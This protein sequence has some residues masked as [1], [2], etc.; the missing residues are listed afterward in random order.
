M[1]APKIKYSILD[2]KINRLGFPIKTRQLR[3][4]YTTKLREYSPT[5][6]IDLLQG[7]INQSVFLRYYYKPFLQDIKEKTLKGIEPLQK[8]LLAIL[9]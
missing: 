8:E 5:E 1:H 3:K 9:S 4:Y 2:T 7:R 6:A